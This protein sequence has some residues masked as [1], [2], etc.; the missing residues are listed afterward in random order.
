MK[1]KYEYM[2]QTQ[3][4]QLFG[5]SSHKIGRWLVAIG[6][7]T[8]DKRPSDGAHHGGFCTTAPSGT[9]GYR[10]VWNSQKTVQA[11]QEAG[12]TLV[13]DAPSELVE[14][15]ALNGPFSISP[16]RSREILNADGSVAAVAMNK[17]AARIVARLLNTAH[18]HDMMERLAQQSQPTAPAEVPSF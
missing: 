18:R 11:L 13:S 6:L 2:T 17:P 15:S 4:G 14:P 7:R 9:S 8:E 1:F 3:L 16:T 10:W 12:H 5:V